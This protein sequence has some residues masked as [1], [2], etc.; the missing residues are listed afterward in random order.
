[1]DA[2]PEVVAAVG[3]RMEVYLEGGVRCGA[4]VAK[5]LSLGARAVFLGR[6]VLWGLAY[7]GKQGVSK[8]L[9]ILK[10]ELD[11]TI[12]LLGCPD[13]KD[14]SQDFVVHEEH[15]LRPQSVSWQKTWTNGC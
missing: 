8:V 9:N 3:H 14:L 5:A 13:I 1:M 2:L 4:D 12:R 11:L 10:E 15:Y 6:P 7:D